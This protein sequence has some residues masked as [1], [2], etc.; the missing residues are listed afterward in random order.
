M[1]FEKAMLFL[2]INLLPIYEK[3]N[4]ISINIVI[5]IIFFHRPQDVV[6]SRAVCYCL[7]KNDK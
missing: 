6:V 3:V 7:S 4:I 2:L 1:I 5:I